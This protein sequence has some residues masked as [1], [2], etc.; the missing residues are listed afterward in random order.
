MIL[1]LIYIGVTVLSV[2]VGFT[3]GLLF[4]LSSGLPSTE[5]QVTLTVTDINVERT[6]EET[7][8]AWAEA[9]GHRWAAPLIADKLR[10][11]YR[12]HEQ[13]GRK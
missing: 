13:K 11:A 7:A 6:I 5:P 4:A 12:L 1:A 10:L 9:R 2:I 8:I 3:V